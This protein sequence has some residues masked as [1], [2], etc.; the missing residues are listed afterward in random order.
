MKKNL[1]FLELIPEKHVT[2]F[3]VNLITLITKH[4]K[5]KIQRQ[6]NLLVCFDESVRAKTNKLTDVA[7]N[8]SSIHVMSVDLQQALSTL[9]LTC[10]P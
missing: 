2:K 7:N 4:K 1:K 6:K 9:M 10:G 8:A 5:G 3:S